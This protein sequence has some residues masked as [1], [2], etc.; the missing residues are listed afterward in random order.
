M[1]MYSMM[2]A[3][4]CVAAIAFSRIAC[5]LGKMPGLMIIGIFSFLPL[6]PTR[7]GDDRL[8]DDASRGGPI[9]G[10]SVV[11]GDG[12]RRVDNPRIIRDVRGLAALVAAAVGDVVRGGG[13]DIFR[14]VDRHSMSPPYALNGIGNQQQRRK[15]LFGHVDD[16]C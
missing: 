7:G 9:R 14:V 16:F 8:P 11:A 4:R 10:R 15:L 3:F 5:S 2:S 13:V 1:A 6:R 12:A